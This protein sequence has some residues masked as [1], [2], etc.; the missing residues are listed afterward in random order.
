MSSQS[1]QLEG[2]ENEEKE[3]EKRISAQKEELQKLEKKKKVLQNI[4]DSLQKKKAEHMEDFKRLSD[5]NERIMKGTRGDYK[6][7]FNDLDGFIGNYREPEKK[8]SMKLNLVRM[9]RAHMEEQWT[10]KESQYIQQL[11]ELKEQI[12]QLRAK[13][14]SYTSSRSDLPDNFSKI[15]RVPDDQFMFLGQEPGRIS[16]SP[17]DHWN[18]LMASNFDKKFDQEVFEKSDRVHILS[19]DCR[20]LQQRRATLIKKL[21]QMP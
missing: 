6:K 20:K 15:P 12:T 21:K 17:D 18:E 10:I 8:A 1:E 14:N 16:F 11:S 19:E 9:R 3:L 4:C 5:E 2:L 7:K 13:I